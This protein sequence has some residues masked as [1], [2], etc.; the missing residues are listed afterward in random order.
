VR[1][2]V[3]PRWRPHRQP[4]VGCRGRRRGGW[5]RCIAESALSAVPCQVIPKFGAA[6]P[7]TTPMPL[8]HP[9]TEHAVDTPQESAKNRRKACGNRHARQETS[10]SWP[11]RLHRECGFGSESQKS[12]AS[13][14]DTSRDA[15]QSPD[16][17]CHDSPLPGCTCPMGRP[18]Q[19]NRELRRNP[20]G[21]GRLTALAALTQTRSHRHFLGA[22]LL[23]PIFQLQGDPRTLVPGTGLDGLRCPR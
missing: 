11:A 2:G 10:I 20:P 21:T 17:D 4:T 1:P 23:D 12:L 22:E 6:S 18:T 5:G 8:E 19:L 9:E 7:A 15:G 16:S 13:Q 14:V 3:Y